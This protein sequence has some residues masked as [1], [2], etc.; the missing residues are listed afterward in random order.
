MDD[1]TRKLKRHAD[2]CGDGFGPSRKCINI[3]LRNV[4][5]NGIVCDVLGLKV[6]SAAY[7][8]ALNRLE[9][10]IDSFSAKG[11]IRDAREVRNCPTIPSHWNSVIALSKTDNRKF[12]EAARCIAES[13]GISR[14]H[15]DLF[16]FRNV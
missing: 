9:I 11:L 16:Y 6:G 4:L 2:F 5:Y 14:V 13:K 15:L 12:Q 10:P 1:Q 8:S 3:Y 7:R